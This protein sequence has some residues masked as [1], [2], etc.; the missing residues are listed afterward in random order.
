MN[1]PHKGLDSVGLHWMTWF[2]FA[3]L[4]GNMHYATFHILG[5]SFIQILHDAERLLVGHTAVCTNEISKYELSYIR[6]IVLYTI[7]DFKGLEG[8]CVMQL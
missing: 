4:C 3:G 6:R 1:C 7:I 5:I 2:L 8:K